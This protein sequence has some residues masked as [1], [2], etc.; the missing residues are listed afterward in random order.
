M[1]KS[2]ARTTE[3]KA[4]AATVETHVISRGRFQYLLV[5]PDG[6][7]AGKYLPETTLP[8]Q[9]CRDKL[10][11][12]IDATVLDE[13]GMVYKPGPTDIPEEDFEVPKIRVE[14][15]RMKE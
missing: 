5:V 10:Q 13:K 9:Y 2:K 4:Q 12:V 8:D 1:V 15:I 7:H 3:M 14:E 11:V 6:P